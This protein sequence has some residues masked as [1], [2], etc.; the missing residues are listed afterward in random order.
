M[1]VVGGPQLSI[2]PEES[3]SWDCFD[4]A[5]VGDGEETLLEIC[6]RVQSGSDWTDVLGT[7]VRLPDG[8]VQKIQHAHF[9]RTSISIQ[10]RHG[11]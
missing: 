5:V 2:Y 10:W 8:S 9:P 4:I 11:T 7:C 1:V 3:L 6:E